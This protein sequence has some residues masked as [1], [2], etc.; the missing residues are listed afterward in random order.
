MG[1]IEVP[2]A[3]ERID[4]TGI[5]GVVLIVG[6]TDT[7]KTTLARYLYGRFLEEHGRAAFVDGDMGQAALGP[8]TTMTVGVGTPD[9][10]GFPPGGPSRRVFAGDISPTGHMLPTVVGARR[11][12]D[13]AQCEGAAAVVCDTT[14]LVQAARG[15]GAL[16]MALVDLLRPEL[17]VGLQRESELEHLLV[18]LRRSGRT[19]VLDFGVVSAVRPRSRDE[20][21]RHRRARY[22]EAF[23]VARR[24]KVRWSDYAVIPAPTF[25]EHRLLA[26][27]DREGFV[28]ALAIVVGADRDSETVELLTTCDSPADVDT[29][30]VGDVAVDPSTYEDRRL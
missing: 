16:K 17:V 20:R 9:R 22:R 28:F 19:R 1:R 8:P 24:L 26:L 5:C 3:W 4:V 14:G 15:G 13:W 18:P 7:G 11:L 25:S 23:A 29:L 2:S 21:R 10:N 6:A 12:V 27:E 30:H